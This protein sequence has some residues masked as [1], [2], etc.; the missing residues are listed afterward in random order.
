MIYVKSFNNKRNHMNFFVAECNYA[1]VFYSK[2][3]FSFY[4]FFPNSI[5]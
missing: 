5:D 3:Q 2:V 1:C 4:R